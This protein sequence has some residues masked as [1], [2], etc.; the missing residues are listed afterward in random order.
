MSNPVKVTAQQLYAEMDRVVPGWRR[1][2]YPSFDAAV[3]AAGSLAEDLCAAWRAGFS[4]K[5]NSRLA[6]ADARKATNER[7]AQEIRGREEAED[8]PVART[9]DT[10]PVFDQ[11]GAGRHVAAEW[12]EGSSREFQ[13]GWTTSQMGREQARVSDDIDD[14]EEDD[15]QKNRG[16]AIGRVED[17]LYHAER[18]NA[19]PHGPHGPVIVLAS[20][21]SPP[22]PWSEDFPAYVRNPVAPR[23]YNDT[24]SK[25]VSQSGSEDLLA[26]QARAKAVHP[27]HNQRTAK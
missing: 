10:G 3:V 7:L 9:K 16:A 15:S 4:R 12:R 17:S 23:S 22:S 14:D 6:A 21:N 18:Y 13:P 1:A 8:E 26:F 20:R 2:N 19:R 24:T 11:S 25:N 27:A 5:T